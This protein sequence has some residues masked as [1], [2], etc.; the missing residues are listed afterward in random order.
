MVVVAQT[1]KIME[2]NTK[3]WTGQSM[4]SLLLIADGRSRWAVIAADASVGVTQ[5]RRGV[6]DIRWLVS[7]TLYSAVSQ[8]LKSLVRE[9]R[10]PPT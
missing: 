8:D 1:T 4:S 3:E 7:R 6:T 9:R 2:H 5:R 10:R